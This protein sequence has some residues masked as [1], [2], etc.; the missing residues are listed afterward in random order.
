[1]VLLLPLPFKHIQLSGSELS[2]VTTVHLLLFH[3]HVG[4]HLPQGLHS[5]RGQ[6]LCGQWTS[7][8]G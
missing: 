8:C 4:V 1:M 2:R 7:L 5:C 3:P 6:S